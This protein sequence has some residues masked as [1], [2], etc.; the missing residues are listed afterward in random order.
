M[1]EKILALIQKLDLK[2]WV[3]LQAQ[4]MLTI[5]MS[6][7]IIVFFGTS[8]LL[9]VQNQAIKEA[10]ERKI[11][12]VRLIKNAELSI[13]RSKTEACTESKFKIL[14]K[15]ELLFFETERVKKEI[16]SRNHENKIF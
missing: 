16:K 4:Q 12:E 1:F 14:E 15:Y 10:T 8:V 9:F 7:L 13:E 2:W 5:L 6:V 11:N 3:S